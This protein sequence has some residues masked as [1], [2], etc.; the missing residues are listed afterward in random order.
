MLFRSINSIIEF[1]NLNIPLVVSSD[2][3]LS[4]LIREP[5]YTC[6]DNSHIKEILGIEIAPWDNRLREYINKCLKV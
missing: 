5:K 3:L 1:G 2:K 4:N 6:T